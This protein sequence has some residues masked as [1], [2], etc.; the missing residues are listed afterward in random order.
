MQV[1]TAVGEAFN[2]I[3]LHSYDGHDDG[4]L[5]IEIQTRPDQIVIQFR[6]WGESFD[7]ESVPLPDFDSLPESGLG[8]FIIK[9]FMDIRYTAGRPNV[10][11]LTK[12]LAG[13]GAA[14][15]QHNVDGE[16]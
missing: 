8:I 1:V 12:N 6:D 9:T 11:T 13:T 2:N 14:E 4:I 3:V 10:L 5:E 7:P 16:Q 15:L